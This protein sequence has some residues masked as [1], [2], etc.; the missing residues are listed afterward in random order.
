MSKRI[1]VI[2]GHPD[3]GSFCGA[4]ADA[5]EAGAKGA[6]HEVQRLSLGELAFDPVLHKGYAEIQPLEPDLL[7]AQ[8]AITD[9]EHLVFVYPVW[10]GAPPAL[11]KGFFDR[12]FLPGYAFRFRDASTTSWDR[13]LSKRSARLIVTMDTP[14]WYYRWVYRQPGHNQMKRTILDFCGIRPVSVSTLGPLKSSSAGE[15]SR[16]LDN[17]RNLGRGAR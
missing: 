17:A 3:S 12:A 10:W 8:E 13:L 15:R 16:W 1:L 4:L 11:L 14:P 5:Y 6:G 7:H 9:A 2:L